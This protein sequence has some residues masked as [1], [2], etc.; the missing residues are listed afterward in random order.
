[1][2]YDGYLNFRGQRPGQRPEMGAADSQYP[3]APILHEI[4]AVLRPHPRGLRRWSVM[5]AIRADRGRNS[6]DVPQKFEEQIERTFRRFC[7]DA[8][9]ATSRTCTAEKAPFYRPQGMAGEVWALFPDRVAA[10]L[11]AENSP[12]I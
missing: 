9:A 7:A 8:T 5:R 11:D 1:M 10:L 12:E 2:N 6:R 3:D 4:I